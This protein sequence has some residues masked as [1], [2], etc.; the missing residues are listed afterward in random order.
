MF[1]SKKQ[2]TQAIEDHSF[3]EDPVEK[4]RRKLS[5]G[6]EDARWG[7]QCRTLS[8]SSGADEAIGVEWL[9]AFRLPDATWGVMR[10][11]KKD[12]TFVRGSGELKG[13]GIEQKHLVDEQG[14]PYV[15]ISFYDAIVKLAEYEATQADLGWK[16]SKHPTEKELGNEY[17]RT[18]ALNEGLVF[19]NENTPHPTDGG[20]LIIPGTFLEEDYL[21]VRNLHKQF[22]LLDVL[23]KNDNLKE[24]FNGNARLFFAD[25]IYLQQVQCYLELLKHYGDQLGMNPVTEPFEYVDFKTRKPRT[26][27]ID[28]LIAGPKEDRHSDSVE[29]EG[30]YYEFLESQDSLDSDR[31]VRLI[32]PNQPLRPFYDKALHLAEFYTDMFLAMS[33]Y[34]AMYNNNA[35]APADVLEY[36]E[37]ADKNYQSIM[38][39]GAKAGYIMQLVLQ[40][41][42]EQTL[43]LPGLDS[44][45][46]HIDVL[47]SRLM[48]SEISSKADL[49]N[50]VNEG[51]EK[52][53]QPKKGDPSP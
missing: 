25:I 47:C 36:V 10:C 27:R 51:E 14:I 29:H 46:S 24:N 8:Y 12:T 3:K 42:N 13:S 20:R 34:R 49:L 1:G 38:G 35:S 45:I 21:K 33:H 11:R 7:S 16:K 53:S 15:N 48:D 19:D 43:V 31:R 4:L 28:E 37:E 6:F 22:D 39:P 2:K 30:A 50:K 41:R 9:E 17:Y 5:H 52:P 26:T 40:S 23:T 32:G 18:F 44:L